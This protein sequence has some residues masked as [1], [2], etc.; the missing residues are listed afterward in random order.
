MENLIDSNSHFNL[1]NIEMEPCTIEL[2]ENQNNSFL[3]HNS[4]KIVPRA[5]TGPC[6]SCGCKGYTKGKDGSYC[7]TCR[8]H[9]DQHKGW[10]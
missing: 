4:I 9:Y 8:H 2:D 7:G 6:K 10:L 3:R 1:G 5:G